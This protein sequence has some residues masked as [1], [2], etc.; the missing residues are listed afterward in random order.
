VSLTTGRG[1]LS[2][3]P[4]GRFSVPMPPQVS[5]AEPFRRRVRATRDGATVIDTE[6]A[7]LLHRPGQPPTFAF[8]E[9]EVAGLATEQD[10]TVPGHVVV[11]WDAVSAWYEEEEEIIGHPRNPY[12]RV[13]C[14]RSER[15][16]HVE[17]AGTVLVDTTETMLV[18][19]TALGPR[20]YVH[21][22]HVRVELTHSAL[23]T[24][25]PY[26]GTAT[27]WNALVEGVVLPDVAWSYENA[28]PESAPLQH[29]VSFDE[30]LVTVSHNLPSGD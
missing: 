14:L 4:A 23:Q 2:A 1:P 26:K 8:P 15:R 18:D 7:V 5:Y 9:R 17:A 16:L 24:Y 13:D 21:P 28:L 12:H 10:D 22:R 20:L 6:R 25:C 11:P 19:E 30:A 27:Y 29:L 3:T